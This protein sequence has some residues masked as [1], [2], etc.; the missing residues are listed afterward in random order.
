MF[1]YLQFFAIGGSGASRAPRPAPPGP[2]LRAAALAG[3]FPLTRGARLSL[4]CRVANTQRLPQPAEF[5]AALG[6]SRK[7]EVLLILSIFD[8]FSSFS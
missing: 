8:I 3:G 6:T 7:R 5:G 1:L 2:L 4:S